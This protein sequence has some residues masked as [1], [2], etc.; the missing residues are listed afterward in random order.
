[1]PGKRLRPLTPGESLLVARR[2][3]GLSQQALGGIYGV[4]AGR[5][6]KWEDDRSDVPPVSLGQIEAREWCFILRRRE[7]LTHH[8]VAEQ[9]GLKAKWVHRAERGERANA[10]PLILFWERRLGVRFPG[11][12]VRESASA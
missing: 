1:M 8:Q 9:L 10:A 3:A 6:K 4:G 5:V 12:P 7:G 11:T 2:R